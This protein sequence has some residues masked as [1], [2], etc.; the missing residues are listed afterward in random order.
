MVHLASQSQKYFYQVMVNQ[1]AGKHRLTETSN[2]LLQCLEHLKCLDQLV[3]FLHLNSSLILFEKVN[4][5]NV[6]HQLKF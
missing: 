6:V 1:S 4:Q 2:Q 5:R 3:L